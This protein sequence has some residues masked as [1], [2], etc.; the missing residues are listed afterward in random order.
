MSY[1]SLKWTYHSNFSSF[2]R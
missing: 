2:G 1:I